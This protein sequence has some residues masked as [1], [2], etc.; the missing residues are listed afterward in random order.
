MTTFDLLFKESIYTYFF[1]LLFTT[2]YFYKGP[3]LMC[4]K[5]QIQPDVS[6]FLHLRLSIST[7][8]FKQKHE[9]AF[10]FLLGLSVK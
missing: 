5:T 10:S 8:E 2:I 6:F 1:A 9:E 7:L 4:Y 3:N